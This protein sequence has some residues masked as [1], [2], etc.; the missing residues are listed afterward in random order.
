MVRS[1]L[2]LGHTPDQSVFIRREDKDDPATETRIRLHPGM[3]VVIDTERLWHVVWHPGPPTPVR[4]DHLLGIQ[5]GHRQLDEPA[6]QDSAAR[7]RQLTPRQTGR[8]DEP[9]PGRL[10]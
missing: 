8:D 4:P 2:E 6:G 1:W 5:L 10:R 7:P 9:D 3:Q